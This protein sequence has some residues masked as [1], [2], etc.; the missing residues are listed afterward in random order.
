MFKEFFL[1]E[2]KGAIRQPMVYIFFALFALMSGFA[3]GSDSVVIGGAIGN[4]YK[5]APHVIT[6]YTLIL[7]LIGLLVATAYFNNAALR[8]YNN[9][10]HEILFSTP[11]QKRDYF[12]G[13]FLGAMLVATIPLLG[14]FF[15]IIVGSILGPLL[16]DLSPDRIGGFNLMAYI[17]NYLIFILPNIFISGTILF[18]LANKFRSTVVSFVGAL[19][20]IILYIISGT[21][22]SDMENET[23]S[24]LTDIFGI[25]TYRVVSQY[26]TPIEKNTLSP[27][28]TGLILYNRLIW[29]AVGAI[30]LSLSYKFFS[31]KERQKKTKST[32]KSVAY[33][34]SSKIKLAL[35]KVHNY[36][37]FSTEIAQF[38]SFFFVNFMSI[39]K[40]ITFKILFLF[41]LILF[42]SDLVGGFEYFGLQSYPVTYKMIDSITEFANLFIFIIIVFFSG[43]LIWRDRL[44]KINEVIDATPHSSIVSLLA[45]TISLLVLVS[46]LYFFLAILA[47]GFQ[48][49][50]GFTDI[51]LD[52]YITYFIIDFIP[53]F[54]AWSGI[55]IFL[56]VIINN[57]YVGYFASILL[58][59][60]Q[61]FLW[62]ILDI[63][64]KMVQI[65]DYPSLYYSDMNGFGPGLKGAL[66]FQSYWALISFIVI[67]IA[68]LL[69][70]RGVTT[71][72]LTKFKG[73][74]QQLSPKYTMALS[75]VGI[76]WLGVAG[77]IFY[78]TQVLNTYKTSDQNENEQVEYEKK[79]KKYQHIAQPKLTSAVYHIDI[80]P[81]DRDVKIKA[82][83]SLKNLSGKRIDSLHFT[84][85]ESWNHKI[86][87]ANAEQV[88]NDEGLGYQIFKLRT[89]LMPNDSI[90]LSVDAAYLSKGFENGA[91]NTSIAQNGTFFN[92]FSILPSFGYNEG[93]EIQDKHKRKSLGLPKRLRI[94]KL[95]EE[96]SDHCHVN[97]LSDG[98]S[99][100]VMVE[101]YISTSSDQVAIAPGSLLKKWEESGRNHYHYKVDH[102]S[103]NFYS[104]ISADYEVAS[105]KWN[106]ID[107]EIYYDKK[108]GYNIDHFINAVEKSL[109][110]YSENF[111][112]Y[113]HKQARIIEFPRYSTFAQAFPGT[114]P[115]SESFGFIIDL[116][117]EDKN[118]VIDA[119]IAHEMAHQWWAHQEVAA[120]MQGGT[121]LTESFAEYSSLMVMK[122]LSDKVKMKEFLKYDHNRY[123]RGRSSERESEQPLY[124]V[125]NQQYIHYG[126][127]SVILYALQDYIGEDKVNR[128][129]KNFLA[130]FRYAQ[131][132]YPTSLD[133]LEHL[134]KEVPDSLN[135]L[136]QDW[137]KEI[138]LYDHRLM[139]ASYTAA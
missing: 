101:T 90:M 20:I 113:Y 4:I 56:Q 18:S 102:P 99:D 76:A 108:H 96:C 97:Y 64:T 39:L 58:F 9:Q 128:A 37:N 6:M 124:K 32:S 52:L 24:A 70:N 118:N 53:M 54:I 132:P 8:D 42:I 134:E 28:F 63:R 71:S 116:E 61:G 82:D 86:N 44:N 10:F 69:I 79:Y 131:P 109:E 127:G 5:N 89:P 117:N 84:I 85:N 21:L 119:V 36:F 11:I 115:Y 45:K 46:S 15:G 41:C 62:N 93:V 114:M 136:I 130:E 88:Y 94:P 19:G 91:G 133:F 29:M 27:S 30:I 68:G 81:K 112:P 110:Y 33:S 49:I 35:P 72:L 22:A 14:I 92:N 50:N 25:R 23:I 103:Q 135:Y 129:L 137:F 34:D 122:S 77:Y 31:F 139:D 40:S 1:R 138:T 95:E 13:R 106:D 111:G 105:K 55:L 126:K 7:T 2:I 83:L 104:F 123:L 38:K 80:Y 17:N 125:E 78:N 12:F 16:G 73:M 3:V 98:L 120:K 57:R 107:I 75:I 74:K 26:Y 48:L 67:L 121:M 43:E 60:I 47:V 51:Q 59:F 100:W 87:I 66:W 65:G